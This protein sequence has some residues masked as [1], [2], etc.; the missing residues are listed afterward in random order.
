MK[1][2][3]RRSRLVW[4]TMAVVMV[5]VASSF[6]PHPS[7]FAQEPTKTPT[8]TPIVP[9]PTKTPTPA[10]TITPT[11]TDTP[12]PPQP[13]PEQ[14]TPT[15]TMPALSA[16]E[17]PPVVLPAAGASANEQPVIVAAVTAIGG[18]LLV[19]LGLRARRPS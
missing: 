6:I 17:G 4:Y 19:G 8:P 12:K 1:K 15:P 14:P 5:I 11:P 9:E 7:A 10:G 2:A 3:T 18:L 13:Q 16:V